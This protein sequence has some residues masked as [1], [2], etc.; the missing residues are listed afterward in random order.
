MK[1]HHI[2][3]TILCTS[4]ALASEVHVS[5]NG[6]DANPGTAA[7][8]FA[9]LTKARDV[10][11]GAGGGTAVLHGGT[12]Q[13]TETLVL[14]PADSGTRYVA[15]KDEEPIL[16][17]AREIKGW[18]PADPTTP[19]MVAAAH[20][21]VL[22]AEVSKGW[23]FHFLYIDGLPATRSRSVNHDRWR[24]W[25]RA[26]RFDEPG[27]NGQRVTF[28]DKNLIR[29]L[30]SNGDVE[31]CAI[32]AQFGVMGGG[33]M[34]DFDPANGTATWH[35][36]QLPL[37]MFRPEETAFRLENALALIDEPGE[38]AVDSA[39]GR[40]YYWPKPEENLATAKVTAPTLNSL[41]RVLG[42]DAA[43]NYVKN[44]SFEGIT[45]VCTDRLPEDEWPDHWSFRQ[46]E[47]PDAMIF[48]E[49]IEDC[50]VRNC[51]LFYSGSYGVT[52]YRH[53]LRNEVSACEIGWTGSGGVQLF[54]FGAGFRDENR[55][56]VVRRNYMHH[57]GSAIYWHSPN[58]QIFG[59][60]SNWIE[61]NFLAYS[62]YNNVSIVGVNFEDLNRFDQPKD[63]NI[64]VSTYPPDVL[65]VL[66]SGKP[67]FTREN[68][69]DLVIH[70]GNNRVARNIAFEC[71]TKLEE[72]GALYAWCPGKG[73]QF[74]ENVVYKG[75]GLPGSSI[76]S[77]DDRAEYFTLAGN[78][79]WCVG[80]AGAGT[81]GVRD[82]E[83][84][85]IFIANVRS[86]NQYGDDRLCEGEPGHE[87]FDALYQRIKQ[88][89][90]KA[91][92]WP[93]NPDLPAMIERLKS[94]KNHY[95]LTP[96]QI[97]KMKKIM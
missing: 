5:P 71:H 90:D 56:N 32:L 46:W 45:M 91:G 50:A 70:S 92:G 29:N 68:F 82:Q 42:D 69:R 8:P 39:A 13:M 75:H 15:A 72:G 54:G 95:E 19:G 55:G 85:N 10:L 7:S 88:D 47:N 14:T 6:S 28:E 53:A 52:F 17:S 43:R 93:G 80:R 62:A 59:S 21:K 31:M 58:V 61:D 89:V 3:V 66:K 76:L 78:V 26:F 94:D 33:V 30:P 37:Q 67:Y 20:G 27:A 63:N 60:G 84:G 81:I 2:L 18:K 77:L 57:Q 64:D 11:R 41:I 38:W 22:V 96:E 9:T 74:L 49:G 40:V 35:S 73:N 36:K 51:R 34:R 16:T 97:R 83:L 1:R 23:R 4:A 24:D 12:Y 48:M 65:A 44:V 87:K 25:G 79:V 86:E